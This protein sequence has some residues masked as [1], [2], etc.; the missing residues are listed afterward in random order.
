MM[1][2]LV[3]LPSVMA[4]VVTPTNFKTELRAELIAEWT[5]PPVTNPVFPLATLPMP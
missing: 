4:V 1:T 5:L 2:G 3:V